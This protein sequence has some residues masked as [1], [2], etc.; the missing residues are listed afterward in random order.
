MASWTILPYEIRLPII[1]HFIEDV[2]SD[3]AQPQEYMADEI[4]RLLVEM[5][6]AATVRLLLVLAPELQG[7]VHSKLQRRLWQ[8]EDAQ[9]KH[10]N[11]SWR[12][13]KNDIA[14]AYSR[15]MQIV[16]FLVTELCEQPRERTLEESAPM[17]KYEESSLNWRIE[18]W[19]RDIEEC[20][21]YN[22]RQASK[23]VHSSP[24][25]SYS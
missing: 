14:R 15:H 8:L 10:C 5:R 13:A 23:S 22:A 24:A 11:K 2:I 7:T 4:P 19:L 21:K 20:A 3:A 6:A 9:S 17:S 25:F 12:P 16:G 1:T 18:Q